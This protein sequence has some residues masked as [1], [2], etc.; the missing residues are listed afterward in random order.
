MTPGEARRRSGAT[1]GG[2]AQAART[3]VLAAVALAAG[4]YWLSTEGWLDG[5]DVRD[6][7]LLSLLFVAVPVL[8]AAAVA[9]PLKLLRSRARKSSGARQ[10]SR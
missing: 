1:R 4:L 5:Q 3:V 9:L 6:Y 8:L 10:R 7:A 2:G